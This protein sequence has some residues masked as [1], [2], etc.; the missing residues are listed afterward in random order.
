[1]VCKEA[2]KLGIVNFKI[3]GGEP[4][5]RRDCSELIKEIYEIDGVKDVTLTTNGIFLEE[6]LEDL[7]SAGVKSINISLDTL[8]RKRYEEITG[9]DKIDKVFQG[10]EKAVRLGVRVKINAVLH[11]E[12]YEEDF[13]SL[14]L[15]SKKYP[16]DVRFIEMMPIGYG[17]DSKLISNDLLLEL[18]KNK[19]GSVRQDNAKRGHGPARYYEVDGLKGRIGFISAIHGV[20]CDSCNRIRMTSTGEVKSCLCFDKGFDL[21]DA[22]N[23]R[24]EIEISE[25]LKQSI[26]EKPEKH[27]FDEEEN[28]T[29]AKKM[30]QIGG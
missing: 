13:I 27:C 11:D 25:I 22:I 18:L 12:H 3:T 10:I 7:V 2:V 6:Q 9:F 28:I 30:I 4:L 16:L 14:C 20:F 1:M 24:D 23:N 29:E 5:V 19:F 21:K 15:L 8:D 26:L 17:A